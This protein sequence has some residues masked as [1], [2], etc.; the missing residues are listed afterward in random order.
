MANLIMI[1]GKS[2]GGGGGSGSG[3]PTTADNV[4]YDNTTSEM[5]ST[6]VQGALDEVALAVGIVREGVETLKTNFQDGVNQIIGAV[7]TKAGTQLDG[8]N[9]PAEI[10]AVISNIGGNN[11][12]GCYL[13]KLQ[14]ESNSQPR[15][16]STYIALRSGTVVL[17]GSSNSSNYANKTY[18]NEGDT[19]VVSASRNGSGDYYSAVPYIQ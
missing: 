3:G 15:L 5:E 7:N 8:S 13:T 16:H 18:V 9:T 11:G 12:S 10:S 2:Y 19:F 14:Y 17:S 4:S 1:D 6:N